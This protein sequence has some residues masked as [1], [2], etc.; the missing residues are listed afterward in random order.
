MKRNL[1]ILVTS[2]LLCAQVKRSGNLLA[3]SYESD[4]D[5]PSE[6]LSLYSERNGKWVLTGVAGIKTD[7]DVQ[8]LQDSL[9]KER[10]DHKAT[11][12]KFAAFNG[13]DANEV[14]AKLDRIDELEAAAGG[15]IDEVKLNEMV[16]TRLRSRTAPLERKVTQLEQQLQERDGVVK[17]LTQKEKTRRI[18][19]HIR[20]AATTAK[21]RETAVEDA[22]V[23]GER[24]LDINENGDVV[25]RDNV[26]VT[27]G[28]GVDVWLTEVQTSRPHWWGESVGAGARGGAG[29]GNISNPFTHENWNLTAQGA[30]LKT[31]RAKAEQLAKAAGTTIGGPKPAPKR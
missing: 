7:E 16:E 21:L 15:K 17:E 19:D 8:R 6:Y 14:Q 5:I 18:H 2:L 9:R 31:N 25:T 4:T 10:E 13:L 30:L 24:I 22:I 20:K 29:L 23:L 12:Q 3:V 27:P 1:N 11:K 26:G 28:V